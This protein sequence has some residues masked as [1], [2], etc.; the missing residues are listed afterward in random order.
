MADLMRAGLG[1]DEAAY[2]QFLRQAADLARRMVRG[3]LAASFSASL[4]DVV[5]E[6]LLAVHLK[7]H[8]WRSDG[9]IV[10]WL[11][12]IA[13]HKAIDAC[14]RRGLRLELPIEDF[15]E[16]LAGPEETGGAMEETQQIEAALGSLSGGQRRVVQ[17]I[18]CD[19]C[20]IS[21]TARALNMK[22]TAVRVAFHRGLRV[23]SQKF[24]RAT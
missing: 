12:A 14:R 7:R 23:I 16:V 21:E 2:A 24:G 18:A 15:A 20:S 4:E 11:A 19:G 5:Q 10:P 8:T 6:T 9:P 1:G 22:E 17:S 3:R 13:R